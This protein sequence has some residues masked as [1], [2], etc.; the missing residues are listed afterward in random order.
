MVREIPTCLAPGGRI[1][2]HTE[3]EEGVRPVIIVMAKVP[4]TGAV[5]TRLQPFLT[6][7]QCASLAEAFLKDTVRM[8][9]SICDDVIVAFDPPNGRDEIEQIVGPDVSLI[10][11]NGTGLGERLDGAVQEIAD[12]NFS[13]VLII[14]TDSPTLPYEFL[15]DAI[16]A[17]GEPDTDLV[18]GGTEDGGYYLIAM[19]EQIPGIFDEIRWSSEHVYRDTLER[20]QTLGL[21]RITELPRWYDVDNPPDLVRIQEEFATDESLASRCP[22][23]HAWL[24][25]NRLSFDES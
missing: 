12:L 1:V 23:T 4:R 24:E 25:E 19:R 18:L 10:P 9:A 8:A 21:T 11:Q 15:I 13:P 22:D 14:G 2:I 7:E 6:A 5:K 3:K 20:A 16:A 17:F